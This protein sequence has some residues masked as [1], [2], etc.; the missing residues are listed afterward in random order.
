MDLKGRD[1]CFASQNSH[2]PNS[3]FAVLVWILFDFIIL[4]I[5]SHTKKK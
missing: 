2:M 4:Q 5:L 3:N 1:I